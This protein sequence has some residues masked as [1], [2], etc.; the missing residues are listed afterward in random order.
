MPQITTT[1]RQ[2]ILELISQ[3]D[4]TTEVAG[5]SAS[6]TQLQIEVAG[7]SASISAGLNE[8]LLLDVP[9]GVAT[10]SASASITSTVTD[11]TDTSTQTITPTDIT[12]TVT[13]G[14]EVNYITI[15]DTYIDLYNEDGAGANSELYLQNNGEAYLSVGNNNDIA[16]IELDP[17]G[18][19]NG[20]LLFATDGSNESSVAFGGDGIIN[21]SSTDGT[22][23]SSVELDPLGNNNGNRLYA[24]DGTNESSVAFGGDGTIDISSTDGTITTSQI[25]SLGDVTT[26]VDDATGIPNAYNAIF[27]TTKGSYIVTINNDSLSSYFNIANNIVLYFTSGD[28][29]YFDIDID[30]ITTAEPSIGFPNGRTIL[31]LNGLQGITN[32]VGE[33]CYVIT[34]DLGGAGTETIPLTSTSTQTITPTDI[35]STVDDGVDS[36]SITLTSTELIFSNIP[37]FDDDTAASGL[38]TNAIYQTTGNGASPLDVA[39]I[40]MIKQ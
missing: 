14:T 13:D 1:N 18:N 9:S 33:T 32:I 15:A 30:Q 35:T 34:P 39:G 22:N 26:I 37:A 25:L 17:L 3:A 27:D 21:I 19:N 40:L 4:E 11:G 20:N 8:F 36:N 28:E 38:T 16:K 2:A 5:L 12:S 31:R 6:V 24:T 7:L 29:I 10:F 23:I